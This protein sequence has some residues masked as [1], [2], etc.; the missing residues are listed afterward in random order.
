LTED[1]GVVLIVLTAAILGPI[2][3]LAASN[4]RPFSSALVTFYES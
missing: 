1:F 3:G 4:S 2:K